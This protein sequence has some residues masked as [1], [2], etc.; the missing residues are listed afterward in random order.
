MITLHRVTNYEVLYFFMKADVLKAI[1]IKITVL[2]DVMPYSLVDCFRRLGGKFCF[3]FRPSI[4]SLRW[5]QYGLLK[6]LQ[7][8]TTL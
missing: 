7:R 3:P 6:R 1:I 4:L 5:G 8:S 2:L